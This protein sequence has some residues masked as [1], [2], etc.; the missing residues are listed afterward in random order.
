MWL[1]GTLMVAFGIRDK[2]YTYSTHAQ[3][4]NEKF[5]RE[6]IQ[7]LTGKIVKVN[8]DLYA[9]TFTVTGSGVLST[10]NGLFIMAFAITTLL[11]GFRWY[12]L[13]PGLILSLA[14]WFK[15]PLWYIIFKTAAQQK[16][17]AKR[18]GYVNSET[19]LMEAIE[20][21]PKA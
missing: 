2:D 13:A 3:L 8:H 21:W 17:K 20:Q 9:V 4:M 16:Y 18:L 14:L 7:P 15:N 1:E 11:F 19:V 6:G 10:V 5:T 12:D